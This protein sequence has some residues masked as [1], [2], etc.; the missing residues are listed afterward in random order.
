MVTRGGDLI[1]LENGQIKWKNTL[2][3]RVA[4]ALL[5]AGGRAFVLGGVD[6]AV[7]AWDAA[8]RRQALAGATPLAMR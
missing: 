8:E 2:G 5:V 4:T 1:A 7:Q 3:A 6:R